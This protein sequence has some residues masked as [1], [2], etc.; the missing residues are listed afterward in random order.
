MYHR[1]LGTE[2][3]LLALIRVGNNWLGDALAKEGVTM[4]I[5]TSGGVEGVGSEL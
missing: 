2:H 4:E 3:L 5:A 1:Y